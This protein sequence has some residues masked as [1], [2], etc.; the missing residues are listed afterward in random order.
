VHNPENDAPAIVVRVYDVGDLMRSDDSYEYEGD[1]LPPTRLRIAFRPS[2]PSIFND[3][4]WTSE[5]TADRLVQIITQLVDP[6]SWRGDTG[7]EL[8]SI[9]QMDDKLVIAQIPENHEKIKALLA[10]LRERGLDSP[11][12]DIGAWWA[13]LDE[14]QLADLKGRST[15]SPSGAYELSDVALNETGVQPKYSGSI[16]CLPAQ[17]V[18]LTA[19][20]GQMIC[21]GAEPVV[22]E[23]SVAAFPH[24]ELVHW[25]AILEVT[26]TILPDDG[27]ILMDLHT[28]VG[29]PLRIR[30]PAMPVM[31]RTRKDADI[32]M[33]S[34]SEVEF[35][36]WSFETT[37][38]CPMDKWILV[39]SSAAKNAADGRRV[40][41]LVKVSIS[42]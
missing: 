1:V 36:L 22:S 27:G 34:V 30:T 40:A 13:F 41:L 14:K 37:A 16:R 33:E 2:G 19:G 12:V 8:G 23:N 5:P 39:G 25:G 6:T 10:E 29:E 18:H 31:A 32:V 38:R 9:W 11:I 3:R 42:D 24:Y 26:P 20:C 7:G 35:E 28:V 17:T 4:M 15:E 21:T